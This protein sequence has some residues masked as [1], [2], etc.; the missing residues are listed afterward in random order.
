ML[1]CFLLKKISVMVI[2]VMDIIEIL[3]FVRGNFFKCVW[4]WP[5]FWMVIV[6]L[7]TIFRN[8]P[9]IVWAYTIFFL[10][11]WLKNHLFHKISRFTLYSYQYHSCFI[12]LHILIEVIYLYQ[13]LL[14]YKVYLVSF[15]L[16]LLRYGILLLP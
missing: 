4:K 12:K 9:K 10:Q 6:G 3:D 16:F 11:Q 5:F 7:Y 8:R 14:F 2:M 15:C 1:K 13:I